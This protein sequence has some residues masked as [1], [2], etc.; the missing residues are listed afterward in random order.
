MGYNSRQV[1]FARNL[2]AR[3]SGLSTIIAVSG[4]RFCRLRSATGVPWRLQ[5]GSLQFN[6][7]SRAAVL[8]SVM[9]RSAHYPLGESADAAH[10]RLPYS[11]GRARVRITMCNG[12]V[13]TA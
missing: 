4:S 6:A 3:I 1:H 13:F 2:R 11:A 8:M 7:R 12:D 10:R 5:S 9:N